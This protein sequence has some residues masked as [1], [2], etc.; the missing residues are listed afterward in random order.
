ALGLPFHLSTLFA[1]VLTIGLV[2]DDAIV[3]VEG[4]ACHI[5][6]GLSG[7]KAAEKAT[8]ELLCPVIDITLVLVA[9]FI[10]ATFL[11]GLTGQLY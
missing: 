7:R 1:I 3:I 5:E 4:V 8:E 9:I 10:P 6:A 2:V 11:S